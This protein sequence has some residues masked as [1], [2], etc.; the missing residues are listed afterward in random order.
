MSK[1]N[2]LLSVV[3]CFWILWMVTA[4]GSSGSSDPVN[5]Q[6]QQKYQYQIP[7]LLGDGWPVEDLAISGVDVTSIET[8]ADNIQKQNAGYAFIQ[9]L[10]IAQNGKLLVSEQFRQSTDFTDTWAGNRNPNLHAIHS[11]TKSINS[12]LL[13]VAI[14]QGY[15]SG[16]D[17]KVH[18]FFTDR[19]VIQNW[20]AHKQTITI[21]NWLNMRSGYLWDEWNVN[22]L[23]A[24]NLNT[25][26]INAADPM[27]FLLDRPMAS[28]PGSTFAYSTGV[29]F[30]LGR[31]IQRATGQS[32]NTYLA[33]NLLAPMQIESFDFWQLDGQLHS[34]SGLYLKPRDMAKFGQMFLDGGMWNGRRIVSEDWVNQSTQQRVNI[35]SSG[36]IGYGYQWWMRVFQVGEQSY[37][38]Y[39]GDGFGGQYVVVVPE[40]EIVIALTGNAYEDGQS[41]QRNIRSIIENEILPLFV[42]TVGMF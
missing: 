39:Y 21:E 37:S 9:S 19:N 7:T 30:G 11:V 32:L 26:M 35:N 41:E 24:S 16:V 33:Q 12:I 6:P 42:N 27:Q 15:I 22:Y 25:Q 36:S 40:L 4:C 20:N 38:A 1:F 3:G 8:L 23:E 10:V 31:I 17:A 2:H 14:E 34:G 18:D 13:G 5:E 28:E 29:S